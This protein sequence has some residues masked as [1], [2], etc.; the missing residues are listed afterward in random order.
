MSASNST[1][2]SDFR[3]QVK[4][5]CVK[6]L[7]VPFEGTG[8]MDKQGNY[9][10]YKDAVGVVTIAWGITTDESNKPITMGT[11]W[12][13]DRARKRKEAILDDFLNRLLLASPM[14]EKQ[15]VRRVAAILSWVYNLG[16]GNYL[17]STFKKR[18]DAGAWGDAYIE[19]KKWDKAGGRVLRGLTRRR[20]SEA[21]LIAN[22]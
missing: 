5:F 12:S 6:E 7:L 8:P 16:I 22:P 20:E 13:E 19:C 9:L 18:I 3:N 1:S 15:P 14:L 10:A 17:K 4:E 11:V 21:V 2:N